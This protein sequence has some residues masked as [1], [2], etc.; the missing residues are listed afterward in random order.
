LQNNH[1]A[2]AGTA[3]EDGA[4]ERLAGAVGDVGGEFYEAETLWAKAVD[5][6]DG[7]GAQCVGGGVEFMGGESGL[8]GEVCLESLDP[9]LFCI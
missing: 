1:H 8:E 7:Y 4:G 5:G 9:V 2:D 6:L 3:Q